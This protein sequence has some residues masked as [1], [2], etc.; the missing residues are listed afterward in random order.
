MG[1]MD[2]PALRFAGR[3]V[4]PELHFTSSTTSNVNCGPIHDN[5]NK[6]WISLWFKLD[7][8]FSGAS[9]THQYMFGKHDDGTNTIQIYM[10]SDTGQLRLYH[11]D[12]PNESIVSAET[13]WSGNTWYHAICSCSTVVGQRIIVNG[14]TAVINATFQ[15]AISL[16][17][18][19]VIGNRDDGTNDKGFIGEIRDV[20]IGIDDL[21]LLLL[22]TNTDL[23][24]TNVV[25]QAVSG[26]KGYVIAADTG[27]ITVART[28]ATAFVTGQDVVEDGDANDKLTSVILSTDE[29]AELY[30]GIIPADATDFWRLNEGYGRS[31]ASLGTDGTTGTID[32]APRWETGLRGYARW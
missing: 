8:A 24:A 23:V 31:V 32:T 15:T 17:A 2:S 13:S 28:N 7:S 9:G 18:D 1:I 26:A 6:L 25:T 20:A 10:D 29:E 11:D 4:S 21:T 12:G 19:F 30:R 16:T 27:Y 3:R 14:G 5:E 22:G